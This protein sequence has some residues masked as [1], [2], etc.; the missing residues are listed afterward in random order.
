VP[1]AEAHAKLPKALSGANHGKV[2]I[3]P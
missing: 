3:K 2:F 1:L